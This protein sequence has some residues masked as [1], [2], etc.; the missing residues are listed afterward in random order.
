MRWAEPTEA[1]A[2]HVA[3]NLRH[4]DEQEVWLSHQIP[5]PEALLTS[6]ADSDICRCIETSDGEPVGFTGVCGDRI[7]LLGTRG[8]TA[9][10]SR[11]LQLC[12]EGRGWVEHC[13]KRVGGPIGNDVYAKNQQSIRWLKHLGF[14]VEPPRPIGHSCALFSRFW[15]E[16]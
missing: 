5:G 16:A 13:L 10:R 4:E 9:T 8:L 11:R 12:I 14:T 6:W 7:W 1:R 2:Y 15:R 3:A